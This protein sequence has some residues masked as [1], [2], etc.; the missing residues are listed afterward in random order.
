MRKILLMLAV[1]SLLLAGCGQMDGENREDAK[2]EISLTFMM[3][4]SHAKDFLLELIEEYEEEHPGIKLEVQRIPD[5]QWIDLVHS[6]AAVGEMPDI[7]RLDKWVLE[8]VD[9]RHFVE[10]GEETS[11]YSRVLPEQLDNKLIDGKLYGLPISATSGLG[12]I[13]NEK[14]FRELGLEIPE[15]MEELYDVCGRI[16][17]AGIIPLYASDKEAWSIQVAFNC[18][19]MQYTDEETWDK[20]KTN[21]LKWSEVEEYKNILDDMKGFREMGYT[22]ED[23][24][25]AAYDNAVEAV[26]EGRAAMYV[27]GQFFIIDVLRKNPE[28]ELMM[29]PFPYNGSDKLSVISG[30]GVFAVCKESEHVKEAKDFLEWF[31]QPEHMNTFNEGWNHPPVFQEQELR[32][33]SWQQYIYDEYI[34]AGKT[35]V[36]IDET[37]NGINLNGLWNNLKEMMAGRMDAAQVLES[38]DED[39]SEQMHYKKETGW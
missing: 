39:F 38:W 21:R 36:Q 15:T 4:Q 14:I 17:Q 23:Y 27:M 6:K 28:C 3:P 8:A 25:E 32:M 19:V 18:M 20:L 24:M 30:A 1:L 22:N 10:F 7:I 5:D 31:S 2:E 11:W 35:V 12:L 16:K 34:S 13:Y 29:T 33:S 37:L 9:T 26:A